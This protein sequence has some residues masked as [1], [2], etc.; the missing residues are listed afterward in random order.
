MF[1]LKD[2]D[3][4]ESNEPNQNINEESNQNGNH[5]E[6]ENFELVDHNTDSETNNKYVK[7]YFNRNL[8]FWLF[9]PLRNKLKLKMLKS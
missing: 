5:M 3:K 9:A 2:G 1:L 6:I 4:E 7:F 8:I